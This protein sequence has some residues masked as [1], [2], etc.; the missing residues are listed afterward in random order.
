MILSRRVALGGA[1]L[2]EVHE[3][4]VIKSVV[5]GAAQKKTQSVSRMHG[6]GNRI[7]S[8]TWDPLK[9]QVTFGIDLP[10]TELALR[11][12]IYDAVTAWALRRG[13]LTTNEMPNRQ[14]YVDRITMPAGSDMRD[15]T[16]DYTIELT[17]Y[18][19]PFWQGNVMAAVS[20]SNSASGSTR[21]SLDGNENSVLNFTFENTSGKKIT[22]LTVITN[23]GKLVL[24]NMELNGGQ[25]VVVDHGNDGLLRVMQR[26]PGAVTTS[27]SIMSAVHYSSSDDLY[28]RPGD[29]TVTFSATRAG[30]L[31][32]NCRGRYR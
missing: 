32:I 21:I 31:S 28:I 12:E 5:P 24:Q 13:W 20:G 29:S 19:V 26:V 7:T 9:T 30:R 4:I 14:M 23:G 8:E 17:A 18:N 11:R 10:K 6:A 2:D 1:Y 16:K 25:S 27:Y 15:W 22:D 3:S